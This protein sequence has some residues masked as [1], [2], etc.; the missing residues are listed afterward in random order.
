MPNGQMMWPSSMTISS[1]GNLFIS[2]E[3]LNRISIFETDGG[4]VGI[5]GECR[6]GVRVNSTVPPASPSTPMATCWSLMA[7]ITASRD[8]RQTGVIWE[9]G[10]GQGQPPASSTFPWGVCN[11]LKRQRIS[12]PTGATTE[13][14]SSM[15]MASLLR[16]SAL[17]VMENGELYRPSGIT[18]DDE[19]QPP[20]RGLGQP[21]RS[22]TRS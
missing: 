6:V 21:S 5:A 22:D 7:S 13:S 20:H 17:R 16:S 1:G 4:F 10:A 14:R 11:G 2:D 9:D 15:P 3:A 12:S 18:L 19:R 8:S